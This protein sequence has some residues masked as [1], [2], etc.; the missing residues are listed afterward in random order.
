MN[1]TISKA[2]KRRLLIFGSI[3]MIIVIYFLFSLT[4]MTYNIKVLTKK[5]K[6]EELTQSNL[7]ITASYL[8]V[9]AAL[10]AYYVTKLNTPGD[11]S[12]IENPI[13]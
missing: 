7:Q 2:S 13:I 12:D 6:N 3:S 9:I 10:I 1:R 4:T 11:I 5:Q 8:S